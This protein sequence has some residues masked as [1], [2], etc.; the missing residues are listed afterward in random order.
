MRN[1]EYLWWKLYFT[2]DKGGIRM[3]DT[4]E[5]LENV[6]FEPCDREY[7]GST[8][9]TNNLNDCQLPSINGK[10]FILGDCGGECNS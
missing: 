4:N 3:N 10:T 8:L 2:L 1:V 9:N 7:T 5:L 6:Q